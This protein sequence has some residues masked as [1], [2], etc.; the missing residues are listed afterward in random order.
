MISPLRLLKTPNPEISVLRLLSE[1]GKTLVKRI[2]CLM[3][4]VLIGY[5]Q[6]CLEFVQRMYTVHSKIVFKESARQM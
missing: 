2:M 5:I 4:L 1:M 6:A 3:I